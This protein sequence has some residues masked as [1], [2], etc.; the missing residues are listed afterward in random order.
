M[1][2]VEPDRLADGWPAVSV[3]MPVLDEAAHLEEAVTR[4]L[5]QDYPGPLEVVL[6]VAPSVDGTEAI[7]AGLA[8]RDARVRVVPNPASST[9]AGLNAALRASRHE[10]VVRVDGHGMLSDGYL[11]TAVAVLRETG[12]DNVGG[13]MAAAGETPFEQAVAW[14]Y[15]SRLG[16]G[17]ARFHVGGA[18]GPAQSVYLGVFRRSTL[19]RLGGFDERYRRAQ[20]WEL[21]YRIRRSGGTVWF[22]PELSVTYRPRPSLGALA[23]QFYLT[24]AWRRRV[25][26]EHPETASARYLAAP[27]LT[28]ALAGGTATGA[29]ALLGGPRWAMLGWLVPGGYAAA[30][31]GAAAVAPGLAPATRVRLPVVLATMH[32]CWG[33]GF[34][35]GEGGTAQRSSSLP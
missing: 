8:D 13:V 20:D 16:L 11:R 32:V 24:G 14:A 35:V 27:L 29:L 10:V 25:V 21:N 34:L 18:A 30:L 3:I 19:E 1:R 9:P 2:D 23:R 6:A 4:V 17:G 28:I 22:T 12:A 15:T 5:A 26:R 31:A 7:A 33:A